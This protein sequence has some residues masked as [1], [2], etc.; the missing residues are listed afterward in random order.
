ML[1]ALLGF[2]IAIGLIGG[3]IG[4]LVR[5]GK[6]NTTG[7]HHDSSVDGPL[8]SS[9]TRMGLGN[10]GLSARHTSRAFHG[11]S[12]GVRVTGTFSPADAVEL[13]AVATLL[14]VGV[15]LFIA[16]FG[17]LFFAALDGG[18]GR[19]VAVPMWLLSAWLP[20]G[21]FFRVKA[22]REKLSTQ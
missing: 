7:H 8:T 11:H 3:G 5:L 14:I 17:L 21:Y 15:S 4:T 20:V 16:S 13:P 12:T 22:E 10:D 19:W 18:A 9:T 2:V 6:A 1:F